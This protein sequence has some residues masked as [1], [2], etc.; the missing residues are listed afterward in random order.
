MVAN[1]K[2]FNDKRSVVY[3]DAERIRKTASNWMTRNNPAYREPGY[4][5][6][7]TPIPGGLDNGRI[8]GGSTNGYGTPT[9]APVKLTLT[10]KAKSSTPAPSASTPAAVGEGTGDFAGLTFQQTQDKLMAD[11]IKYTDEE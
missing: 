1:A 10:N 5:A 11:M 2:F 3:E 6:Q 8:G 4:V 7:P 9:P